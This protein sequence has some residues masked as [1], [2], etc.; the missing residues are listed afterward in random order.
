MN[1]KNKKYKRKKRLSVDLSDIHENKKN[2]NTSDK[3]INKYRTGSI[4]KDEEIHSSWRRRTTK[5][6]HK[7]KE[8]NF[9]NIV[10]E[11]EQ[12]CKGKKVRFNKIEVINVESWKKINLKL[13]SEENIDELIKISE[14]KKGRIKNVSCTCAIF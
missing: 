14:G 8:Y 10:L 7:N 3:D 2:K 13:T 1:D 4:P 12:D 6:S 9:T 5:I 11:D